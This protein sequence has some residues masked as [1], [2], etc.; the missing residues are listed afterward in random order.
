MAEIFDL[1][2]KI[3]TITAATNMDLHILVKIGLI[4]DDLIPDDL[5]SVWFSHFEIMQEIGNLRF[6]RVVVPED[7][8]NPDVNTIDAADAVTRWHALQHIP[9]FYKGM[10]HTPVS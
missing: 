2:R 5:R 1:T 3:T 6:Q 8:V 4:W 7:A 10:V 9:N